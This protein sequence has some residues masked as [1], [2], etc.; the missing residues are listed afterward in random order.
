MPGGRPSAYG[1]WCGTLNNPTAEE[2][3]TLW[4]F[5][6]RNGGPVP[7]AH[8]LGAIVI[9]WEHWR[10][11]DAAA[12]LT[13]HL[14]V[15]FE[16]KSTKARLTQLRVWFPRAHW[17]P[18]RGTALE[19]ADYCRK[20]GT[21]RERGR[22]S[23]SYTV[24][25]ASSAREWWQ[26]LVQLIQSKATFAAVCTDPD[27][28]RHVFNKVQWAY[29]VWEARPR[30]PTALDMAAPG[31]RWQLRF[32][33]FLDGTPPD[34]RKI[35]YVLDPIGGTGKSKFVKWAAS[36]RG[37]MVACANDRKNNASMYWGQRTVLVDVPRDERLDYVCLEKLKDG[38]MVQTKYE[39]TLKSYDSPH[40]IV[41]SNQP[42]ELWRLSHDRWN[43]ITDLGDHMTLHSLF[44][45]RH[46]PYVANLRDP[47]AEEAGPHALGG[48]PP[49]GA[50]PG[51]GGPPPAPQPGRPRA[52]AP[53]PPGPAQG[54]RRALPQGMGSQSAAVRPRVGP[55]VVLDDAEDSGAYRDWLTAGQPGSSAD[56]PWH[57]P[58]PAGAAAAS[59]HN[60]VYY[61][62]VGF[63]HNVD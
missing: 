23:Y 8:D 4:V 14:Q 17:E 12:G 11:A 6:Q 33:V 42:P 60:V 29:K 61:P 46:F 50:G 22:W 28:G 30:P 24:D 35:T 36:A 55:V 54:V 39:T 5:N 15:Y 48:G 19:A 63:V 62:G 44:P 9:G 49:G 10:P 1:H 41:F 2:L 45:V 59:T 34:D 21:Y 32:A 51:G 26:Q 38:M 47:F 16:L 37:W 7:D 43:V 40:L 53:L 25:R 52:P 13:A 3:Q 20:D 56:P 27:V 58:P 31:F 57:P 18:R